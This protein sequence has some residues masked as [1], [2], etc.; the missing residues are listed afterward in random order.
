MKYKLKQEIEHGAGCGKR[1]LMA[2]G[3]N[4]YDLES[5]LSPDKGLMYNYKGLDNI[6]IAT[7]TLKKHID[8][9]SNIFIQVDSDMDG[10]SSAA[11]MYLYIKKLNP[12]AKIA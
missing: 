5:Y 2:R 7:A 1:L 3:I 11:L 10:F 9:D 4:Q 8:K 12:E 6:D